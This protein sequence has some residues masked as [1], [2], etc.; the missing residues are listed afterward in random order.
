MKTEKSSTLRISELLRKYTK[1]E[2]QISQLDL[3]KKMGVAPA[4]VNKWVKDGSISIDRIPKLCE[5]LGIS[6]NELFGYEDI[7]LVNEALRLYQSFKKYP[8][9]QESITK[10]LNLTFEDISQNNN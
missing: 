7:R 6:P 2:K 8:E 1:E 9:Y 3:A 4:S 5:V 10:L